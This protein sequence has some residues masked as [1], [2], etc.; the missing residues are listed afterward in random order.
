VYASLLRGALFRDRQRE[1]AR[2]EQRYGLDLDRAEI[3]RFQAERLNTI[4]RY[5]LDEVPF[6]RSWAAEH[7]LPERIS[8]LADLKGF[9]VL[10]K[11]VIV[12]RGDEVFQGGAID[13]AYS[14]GGTSGVPARYP[15]GKRD[16]LGT[17]ANTY[18]GRGWWG[19]K[20]FDSY[21]HIWGHAHLFG[22]EGLSGK[23]QKLKRRA[24]D[25]LV[26]AVRVNGYDMTAEAIESHYM[27][28][29]QRNPTYVVGYTSAIFRLARHIEARGEGVASLTKL[30]AVVVTAETVTRA[31]VDL[32]SGV[33]QVPVIIEYGA[34]ETGVMATSRGSSW[35]LQVLWQS[36]IV[37]VADGGEMAVTTLNDRLFPLI[38][39]AIGDRTEGGDLVDG[40]A[41]TLDAVTGRSKDVV[42]VSTTNGEH[43]ELSAILPV[44]ILKSQQ[45]VTAVQ[46]RQEGPGTLRIYLSADRELVLNDVTA[47]FTAHLSRDHATYDPGSVAF[48]QSS[49]PMLTKAGKQ[50]L[51]V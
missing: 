13:L 40:N 35:P 22:G 24:A 48:E 9:P 2:Y 49:E 36:F 1:V 16:A 8:S 47:T 29:L 32:I 6:Y 33:F 45:G 34:A 18:T 46:F 41:L 44:H 14:T 10:T 7:G 37:S 51:F 19:I 43:L 39:Y 17:Y 5:C 30:R 42:V 28:L 27:V 25:G 15:R 38:N 3:E 21:L 12:E 4:W 31:D 11:A 23:V 50:A 20:P 26:N